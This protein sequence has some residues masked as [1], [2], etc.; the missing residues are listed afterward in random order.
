MLSRTLT[1]RNQTISFKW[2]I[3]WFLCFTSVIMFAVPVA[4]LSW[5]FELLVYNLLFV[6]V[7]VGVDN[8]SCMAFVSSFLV[9]SNRRNPRKQLLRSI[10]TQTRF[11]LFLGFFVVFGRHININD[12]VADR[13]VIQEVLRIWWQ[14]QRGWVW[15][16]CVVADELVVLLCLLHIWFVLQPFCC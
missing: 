1:R 5:L 13:Y 15:A 8:R 7:L 12:W 9:V 2:V 4:A 16:V 10:S 3:L 14:Q 6:F 11:L